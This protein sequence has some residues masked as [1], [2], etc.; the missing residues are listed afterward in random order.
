M[1]IRIL[2]KRVNDPI[3]TTRDKQ[4]RDADVDGAK[5]PEAC[6]LWPEEKYMP[7]TFKLPRYAAVFEYSR[8]AK[9]S[10]DGKSPGRFLR[11]VANAERLSGVSPRFRVTFNVS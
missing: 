9:Y 4:T 11:I 7:R 5:V 1:E 10:N 3:T 8:I 2:T 6:R